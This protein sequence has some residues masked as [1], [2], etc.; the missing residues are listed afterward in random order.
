MG[1]SHYRSCLPWSVQEFPGSRK[2]GSQGVPE[3][4]LHQGPVPES[5]VR[6]R[7]CA[8]KIHISI[9][10]STRRGEMADVAWRR[11]R[12]RR[13]GSTGSN[14]RAADHVP[15]VIAARPLKRGK[16]RHQQRCHL[17]A[18]NQSPGASHQRCCSGRNGRSRPSYS[19]ISGFQ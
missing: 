18:R 11:H 17:R 13:C 10:C 4:W 6:R 14:R 1:F 8:C 15:Y 3:L 5:R 9:A 7:A 16:H 12:A 2:R 19:L